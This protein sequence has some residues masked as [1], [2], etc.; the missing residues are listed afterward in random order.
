MLIE[1]YTVYELP[2]KRIKKIFDGAFWV[3]VATL[4]AP[5]SSL[6]ILL[7]YVAIY[8]FDKVNWRNI[9]IPLIGFC[10]P[11][12]IYVAYLYAVND[13]IAFKANVEYLYSF[14]FR[15]FNSATLLIHW[16]L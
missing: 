3:G 7:I 6:A 5:W 2:K 15:M 1:E 4:I 9:I 14:S 11:I 8:L 12:V 16:L 10:T 13:I